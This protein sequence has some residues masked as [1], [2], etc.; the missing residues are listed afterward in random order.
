LLRLP[1]IGPY[2]AGAI[3]AFAFNEPALFI[4][5]NIRSAL[6]HTFFPRKKKVSDKELF[7]LLEQALDTTHPREWYYAL[8]DYGTHLKKNRTN[9]NRQSIHYTHQSRFRGSRRELRGKILKTLLKE[10]CTATQLATA[11]GAPRA[12]LLFLLTQLKKE[13]FIKKIKNLFTVV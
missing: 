12:T 8:M 13:G 11:T 6:I 4:E 2:T 7:P 1:G 10:P 3:R 9:P 5:T